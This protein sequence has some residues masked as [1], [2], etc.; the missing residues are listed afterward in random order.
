MANCPRLPPALTRIS[1]P[2]PRQAQRLRPRSPPAAV[3]EAGAASGPPLAASGRGGGMRRYSPPCDEAP[4]PELGSTGRRVKAAKPPIPR[5]AVHHVDADV[6]RHVGGAGQ[7]PVLA[8]AGLPAVAGHEA[9][10]SARP[11]RRTTGRGSTRQRRRW[12]REREAREGTAGW[13][14]APSAGRAGG[15]WLHR[16]WPCGEHAWRPHDGNLKVKGER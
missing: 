2:L 1:L 9:R 4:Q 14:S 6:Q 5:A 8:R 13:G 11:Q 7:L 12:P 3:P 15:C 10:A 16:V